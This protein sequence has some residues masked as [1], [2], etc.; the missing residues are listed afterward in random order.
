VMG[1]LAETLANDGAD[2]PAGARG[3]AQ[4]PLDTAAAATP[5]APKPT[6]RGASKRAPRR[7][8]KPKK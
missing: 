7:P 1:G 6:T 8:A 3:A 4:G 2:R 5:R